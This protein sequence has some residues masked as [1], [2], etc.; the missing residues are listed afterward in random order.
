MRASDQKIRIA[1]GRYRKETTWKN[2]QTTWGAFVARLQDSRP[3]PHSLAEYLAL[4]KEEQA[5]VKDVGGFVGG[6]L[7]G[8]RR[9][10]DH[11]LERWLITLD[12]DMAD[13]KSDAWL[14]YELIHG[15]AAVRYTTHKHSPEA[16]RYRWVILCDRPVARD[17]YEPLARMIASWVGIDTF[18][19]TTYQ[20]ERLMY[21]PSHPRDMTP[22]VEVCDGPALPVDKVLREYR[23]WR[24]VSEWPAAASEAEIHVREMRKLEDPREKTGYIGAFCRTY[25]I[26]DAIETFLPTK[27]TPSDIEGRWT[28][29]EGST[30]AG[31]IVY[32]DTFAYSHHSTDPVQGRACNAFD[33]V[34]LHL[35]GLKDD[36]CSPDTPVGRLPSYEAMVC[37]CTKDKA[38]MRLIAQEKALEIKGEF[39]VMAVDAEGEMVEQDTP[40]SEEDMA[41]EEDL[42]RNKKTGECESTAYNIMLILSE[43]PQLK[44]R[45]GQNFF[46]Q[47]WYVLGKLPWKRDR[48]IGDQWTDF[49]NAQLRSFLETRYSV[50]HTQKVRDCLGAVMVKSGFHPVQEYL[51][52]LRWDGT[53]RVD[54]ML[55]DYMGAEDSSYTRAVARKFMAAAVARVM[56]PGCKFDYVPVLTG[57]QG[58]GKSTLARKLGKQW[59][60]DSFH[61]VQG[62]QSIEQL[63]GAW[64]MEM[65]ELAGLRKVEVEAIKAFISR[66]TDSYRRPYAEATVDLPRQ[67][68]FIGTTNSDSFLRDK[69]GNR[70]F[71]PV[72]VEPEAAL[73]SVHSDLGEEEVDQMWAEAVHIWKAGEPLYMHTK[74]LDAAAVNVQGAHQEED[75]RVALIA[76]YLDMP[77]P[78]N[79]ED[80]DKWERSQYVKNYGKAGF[81]AG[82]K[83][84]DE[85]GIAEIWNDVFDG[86]NL[87]LDMRMTVFI[88]EALKI[89]GGWKKSGHRKRTRL[90][91]NVQIWQKDG[92]EQ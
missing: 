67:C 19:P 75:G 77:I 61:A 63:Q 30:A 37:L 59:F 38:V 49:D 31:M 70:R 7:T 42:D 41:W 35:Y 62:G 45:F 44:G 39:S 84:R 28:Y 14:D 2:K 81:E 10:P 1:T 18:D 52:G 4:P 91:G 87:G 48:H 57:R 71:W 29:C 16:P 12:Q 23:D 55:V 47:K 72:P 13:P 85:V 25:G 60:K 22:R 36:R 27:Y 76:G 33:L 46:D 40:V 3:S 89:I 58:V 78:D 20:V 17:E 43:H 64:I 26:T 88:K 74:L 79:W 11:V 8:G 50:Y 32:D 34:R 66:Q 82:A 51:E 53:G 73:F 92:V 90:F 83:V 54:T 5:A 69:S 9:K 86:T 65:G 56:Q 80:L 6:H 68:V 21:W 15:Y 24:D